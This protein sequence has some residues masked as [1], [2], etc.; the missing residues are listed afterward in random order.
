[1]SH[2]DLRLL[3]AWGFFLAFIVIAVFAVVVKKLRNSFREDAIREAPDFMLENIRETLDQRRQLS[4][5]ME[6]RE[7]LNAAILRQIDIGIAI[8][9]PLKIL[10]SANPQFL[11]LFSLSQEVIGKSI[12]HLQD[13]APQLFQFLRE[14]KSNMTDSSAPVD[15]TI[16][17]RSI[18][19]RSVP[20]SADSG[21]IS[22]Y[23]VVAEDVTEMEAA[24]Q[25]LELKKRLEMLGEMAAG[26][27]HEFR[28][29]LSTLLGYAQMIAGSSDGKDGVQQHAEHI[30]REARTMNTLVDRFL[31]FAK[32]LDVHRQSMT[33]SDLQQ[34]VTAIAEKAGHPVETDIPETLALETDRVLL[35]NCLDNLVRNS[36]QHFS[37]EADHHIRVVARQLPAAV[38]ILVIDDGP[39]MDRDTLKRACIP[40]FTTR[41]EGT[42]LGLAICEK[43]ITRLGGKMHIASAPGAGTTVT[44]TI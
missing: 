4:A 1:M 22:G 32:P 23:L 38:E 13:D 7:Q 12:V 31:L 25:E 27:A 34:D 37:G 33:G 15:A 3:V 16:H 9:D 36:V 17:G 6:R 39:G 24:K 28:N 11:S 8:L 10:K 40:F 29:G 30:V 35:G 2:F 43:I 26:L 41:S 14:L 18:R 19:M 5:E 42:G 21:G 44:V 20:M